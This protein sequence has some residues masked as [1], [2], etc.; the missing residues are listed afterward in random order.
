M[1]QKTI[2][3]RQKFNRKK[4]SYSQLELNIHVIKT[5]VIHAIKKT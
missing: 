5:I 4:Y 1:I 3:K 2:P